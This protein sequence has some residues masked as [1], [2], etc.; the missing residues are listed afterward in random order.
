M[1]SSTSSRAV[2]QSDARDT[3]RTRALEEGF[4]A[5]GFSSA[6][7][8]RSAA[9]DLR[10]FLARGY[11]GDMAWM[12][13]TAERRADPKNLWAEARSV[14][15]LGINYGP[16]SDPMAALKERAQ[17]AISV[18]AHGA[19]YHDVIKKKLKRLAGWIAET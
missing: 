5:V 7:T 1:R 10:E 13:T 11:H 18:Y 9:E 2:L 3:I 8:P 17:G 12:E 16:A 14:I 19:D 4:D 6:D 15:T